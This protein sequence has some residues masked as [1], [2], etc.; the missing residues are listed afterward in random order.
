MKKPFYIDYP[1]EHLEDQLHS[2]RCAHCKVGTTVINGSLEGHLLSCE[3]RIKLEQVGYEADKS[4][5]QVVSSVSDDY[6]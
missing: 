4:S 6:D 2:Y 1:Q 5:A 3:Y